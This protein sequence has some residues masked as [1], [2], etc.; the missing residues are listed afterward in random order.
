[1]LSEIRA[2]QLPGAGKIEE[3]TDAPGGGY[4]ITVFDPEG[5]PINLVHGQEA[6][7][8]GKLPEKLIYN[9]E[10]DKPREGAFQRFLTGP[11]AVHKVFLS[12]IFYISTRN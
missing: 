1:V 3:M 8:T 7:E 5:F 12:P 6:S 2:A 4:R 9:W 10:N 11:A